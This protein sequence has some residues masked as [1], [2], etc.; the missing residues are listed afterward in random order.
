MSLHLILGPMFSGKSTRLI[1]HIR[2]F[3]TLRYNIVIIKPDIDKRYSDTS[4]CTH[5]QDMETCIA[6]PV[7]HISNVIETEEYKNADIIMIEEGQF[8]INLYKNVKHML[9]VDKKNIYIAA[10][11]GDSNRNL[12]GEIY[13]LLPL[14]HDI[15]WLTSLCIR[16]KNGTHAIYSKKMDN[17]T[18]QILIAS[19]D[20]YEAVCLTHYLD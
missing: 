8:F 17:N 3:R 11:N 18:E 1:Q 7:D 16:C 6:I 4:I 13:M 2:L 5:N 12:F 20:K 14:C 15:E 9:D 19:N 10:L